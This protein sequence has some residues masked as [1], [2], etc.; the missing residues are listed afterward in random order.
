MKPDDRGQQERRGQGEGKGRR[1]A[2][3]S[4]RRD[5][6]TRERGN[7]QYEAGPPCPW[8]R[9]AEADRGPQEGSAVAAPV[10]HSE[11]TQGV[12][13]ACEE[14]RREDHVREPN[15]KQPKGS[16]E[17]RDGRWVGAGGIGMRQEDGVRC[18]RRKW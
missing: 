2:A 7:S 5:E 10:A 18:R 11:E 6:H 3:A 14:D 15:R 16:E 8:R 1:L 4:S 12:E 9:D 17:D 13:Q